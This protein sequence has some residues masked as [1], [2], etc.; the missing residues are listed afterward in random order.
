MLS[1]ILTA[2][3]GDYGDQGKQDDLIVSLTLNPD[4]TAAEALLRL[5]NMLQHLSNQ[6]LKELC[7]QHD[8]QHK[9]GTGPCAFGGCDVPEN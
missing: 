5:K 9:P 3:V 4:E 2:E 6:D 1:Y 8:W 7:C